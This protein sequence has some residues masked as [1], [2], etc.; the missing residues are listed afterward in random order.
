M[1]MLRPVWSEPKEYV[2]EMAHVHGKEGMAK[3]TVL[4]KN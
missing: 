1:V 4:R 2:K 3:A